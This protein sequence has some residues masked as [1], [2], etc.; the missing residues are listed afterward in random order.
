MTEGIVSNK[1]PCESKDD[2]RTL[3]AEN[4]KLKRENEKL[5]RC[6]AR[7]RGILRELGLPTAATEN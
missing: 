6:I 5:K 1:T 4:E 3:K 2:S 7:I